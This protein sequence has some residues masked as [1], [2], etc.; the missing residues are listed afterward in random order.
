[1]TNRQY[2]IKQKGMN[3]IESDKLAIFR[4]YISKGGG[5]KMKLAFSTNAFTR[6]TLPESI[7]EIGRLGYKGV[8]ILADVP[9]A[10]PPLHTAPWV[11]DVQKK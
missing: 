4:G 3:R 9:H 6:H 2:G 11:S 10:F 7:S 5:D 8:E 1:M